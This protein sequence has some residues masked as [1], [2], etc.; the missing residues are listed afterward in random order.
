MADSA[1]F[2]LVVLGAGPGGYSC[3]LR[4]AALG[5][6]VACVERWP[7]GE[8]PDAIA[9]EDAEDAEKGKP[10]LGGTCLLVGCIPSKALL[11][12]SW[13]YRQVAQ[14]AVPGMRT[15]AAP[16]L[17]LPGLMAHKR[18]VV[19]RL[20]KGVEHLLRSAKVEVLHGQGRLLAP[21][22]VAVRPADGGAELQLQAGQVVLATGSSPAALPCMEV[23]HERVLDS[24]DALG[25]G[26][27]PGRLGVVGAGAVGLEL[28]SVWSRYGA[29]VEVV[30]ALDEVLAPMDRDMARLLV[31][32]LAKQGV[33][34]RTGAPVLSCE[35]SDAGV[36]LT[37]GGADGDG[38]GG[39]NGDGEEAGGGGE[40]GGGERLAFDLVLSAVGRV[41]NSAGLLEQGCG[42]QLDG[43][44]F[45]QVDENCHTGA[46][47]V[48]A[49]GDLVRGPM[50]A[51][52]AIAEAEMVAQRMA[53]ERAEVDLDWVPAVVYTHPEAAWVGL[54]EE[55]AGRQG[56][57]VRAEKGFFAANGR[58]LGAGE[59]EGAVKVVAGE[60]GRVLGV[61]AVGP[62]AGEIVQQG[63]IAMEFGATAADIASI[64]FAHP[65][66]SEV[67]HEASARLAH[68]QGGEGRGG[69][70]G[71][72]S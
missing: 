57:R 12:S 35:V 39:A 72:G 22:R 43:R 49:I 63:L 30:E 55:A 62:M 23:D 54:G 14:G 68:G 70:K 25:L 71:G 27:V 45:V 58:A 56:L 21:G 28:A 6:R 24:T 64:C 52:K 42:V 65:G 7:G 51:H 34:V 46:E 47:G 41:P 33:R 15:A 66:N 11:E 44:G 2:D 31:R 50:L 53:G 26:R 13:R 59:A 48:W 18:A 60:D 3:A 4:A 1:S 37:V 16:E 17:D 61:Q 5:M 67:L 19:E 69:K 9:A 29:E 32:S 10:T 36:A 40:A 8:A 20:S 38:S